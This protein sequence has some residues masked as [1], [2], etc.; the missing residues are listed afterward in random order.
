MAT[1]ANAADMI[2]FG[3]GDEAPLHGGDI[4]AARRLFPGAPEPFIDLSTGI[5]PIPYPLPDLAGGILRAAAGGGAVAALE[6]RRR[7]GL[8]GAL[9]G[10]CRCGARD[11]DSAAACRRPRPAGP[12]RHRGAD[13]FGAQPGGVACRPCGYRGPRPRRRRAM[14]GLLSSPIQTIRT[15]GCSRSPTCSRSP[16]NCTRAAACWWSMRP[17]WMSGRPKRA[18]PAKFHAAMSSCCARSANSSA[19]PVCGSALRLRR[20][21]LPRRLAARLGPWAVSGPAIAV[22]TPALADAGWTEMTK[23]R[24]AQASA[25]LDAL[26]A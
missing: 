6:G 7:E 19:L 4:G 3:A 17:S 24:L 5:N 10:P 16:S 21:R 14:P 26:L 1:S 18:S 25:R 15:A 20:R 13:L 11:P 8:W 12:R 2:P 22:G 23:R 9:D